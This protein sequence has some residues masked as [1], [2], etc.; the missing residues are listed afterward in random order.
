MI[1]T[2]GGG[3]NCFRSGKYKFPE[4]EITTSGDGNIRFRFQKSENKCFWSI[5][6]VEITISTPNFVEIQI[7]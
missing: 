2:K 3:N 5:K 6:L 1:C 4:A 7:R